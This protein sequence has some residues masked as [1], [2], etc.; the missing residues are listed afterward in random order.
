[1]FTAETWKFIPASKPLVIE[2]GTSRVYRFTGWALTVAGAPVSMLSTVTGRSG[3]LAEAGTVGGT[4]SPAGTGPPSLELM[5]V[6]PEMNARLTASRAPNWAWPLAALAS[7]E[8]TDAGEAM[9]SPWVAKAP[10]GPAYDGKNWPAPGGLE[11]PKPTGLR[12]SKCSRPR[13]W[14]T[15]W[16]ATV[17]DRL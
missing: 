4:T 2:S 15:S 3:A 14:P 6:P 16:A 9:T 12:A 7:V 13:V 17:A 5:V 11:M 8:P 10:T 1:M